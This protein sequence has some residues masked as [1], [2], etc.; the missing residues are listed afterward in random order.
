MLTVG[1]QAVINMAVVTVL[2]P[3][4][5]IALPLVSAGGTGWVLTATAVG[6][7]AALDRANHMEASQTMAVFQD[8]R[9]PLWPGV[10]RSSRLSMDVE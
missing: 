7:V 4:K 9:R 8:S 6:L 2:V 5:G 3:T 1:F 10:T